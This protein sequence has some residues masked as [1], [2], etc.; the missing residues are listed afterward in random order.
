ML[1]FIKYYINFFIITFVQLKFNLNGK[2]SSK[3]GG[4]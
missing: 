4:L 2:L 1:K 3:V